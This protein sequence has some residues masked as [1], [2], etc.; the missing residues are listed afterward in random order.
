M[1]LIE[2]NF[3]RQAPSDLSAQLREI[4][5]AVDAGEVTGLVAAF[6]DNDEY[7]FLFGA[8]LSEAIV[9][10]TLLQSRNVGRMM[11]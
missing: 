10:T 8:S 2:G 5:D 6:V 3:G 9:L 1:K 7:S 11:E 4:A